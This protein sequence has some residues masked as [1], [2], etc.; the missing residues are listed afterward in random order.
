MENLLIEVR[1]EFQIPPYFPDEAIGRYL[2]EGKARLDGLNPGRNIETDLTFRSL[3]K[4]YA[5]YAYHHKLNEWEQNYAN[6]ILS[7]QL[8][9]EVVS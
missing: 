2:N 4:N 8:G 1:E 3:L 5:Y 7:W 9:S 6:L